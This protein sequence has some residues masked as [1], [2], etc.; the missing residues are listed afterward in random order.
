[1]LVLDVAVAQ[2]V[3]C[4]RLQQNPSL[5]HDLLAVSL[6]L[7]LSTILHPPFAFDFERQNWL[8][9]VLIEQLQL[10]TLAL[11]ASA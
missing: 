8:R 3:D 11:V 2:V 4:C 5:Q 10:A 6:C 1:M 7:L 9:M